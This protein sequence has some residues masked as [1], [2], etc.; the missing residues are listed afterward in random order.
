ML[1]WI[2]NCQD[3][4]FQVWTCIGVGNITAGNSHWF[5]PCVPVH[6]SRYKGRS[7]QYTTANQWLLNKE[8]TM[9]IP[10]W[11]GT[12]GQNPVIY[13][14]EGLIYMQL[15]MIL[16]VDY[17][18]FSSEWRICSWLPY[19]PSREIARSSQR[20]SEPAKGT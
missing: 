17:F 9:V 19:W 16:S 13:K 20:N 8:R 4:G 7:K 3:T 15:R 14:A 1:Y 18:L 12:P 6:M 10:L 2:E 11:T 5:C